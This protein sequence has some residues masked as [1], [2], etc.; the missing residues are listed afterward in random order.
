M[1]FASLKIL[2]RN[3]VMI[4]VYD[5]LCASLRDLWENY[6]EGNCPLNL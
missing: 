4:F 5:Y 6:N 3:I 1:C 2:K